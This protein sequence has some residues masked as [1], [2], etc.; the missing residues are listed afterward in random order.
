MKPAPAASRAMAVINYMTVHPQMAFTLSEL[1]AALRVSPASM[2]SILLALCEWGYVIRDR[3]HR[4]YALGPAVVA[5]GHAASQRHPVIE[6]ARP[7]LKRL[8]GFGSE[9]IGSAAVAD[10]ILILAI[11]GR[12]SIQSRE[13]WIGQRIPLIPPFGQV[14]LAWA[15]DADVHKWIGQLGSEGAARHGPALGEDLFRVRERGLAI[16]LRNG[17]VDAVIELINESAHHL[18]R[19]AEIHRALQRAIPDQTENY[20]LRDVDP[21]AQYDVANLAAPVF[22][23]DGTVAF[24]M[25]LYGINDISGSD[26]L[27]L[28]SEMLQ[29]GRTVTRAVG[30]RWASSA[31][32]AILS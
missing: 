24:A 29:S 13:T 6:A 27:D 31:P 20:S 1:S 23:P 18:D 11:E 15:P 14:F 7:E 19:D 32:A 12:P 3:R 26:L 4:T 21:T 30:G 5:A 2:S 28:C 16:G 25:T 8:S 9:C 17:P 22:G 10:E